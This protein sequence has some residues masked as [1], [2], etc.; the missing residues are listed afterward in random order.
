ML[1]AVSQEAL[2]SFTGPLVAVTIAVACLATAVVLVNLFVDFLQNDIFKGK[3][4]RR[5]AIAITC[6]LSFVMSLVGFATICSILGMA[7][8]VIY[9]ALI[10]FS[11]LSIVSK[12]SRFH[13]APHCFWVTLFL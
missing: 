12:L 13:Y 7:L 2:G 10:V 5:Y 4:Q 6:S 11:I 3:L 9:P 8:E 1:V